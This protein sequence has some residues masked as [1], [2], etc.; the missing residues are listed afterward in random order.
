LCIVRLFRA[1]DSWSGA[2][3]GANGDIGENENAGFDPIFFFLH[4]NVDRVFW[5]WQ[6]RHQATEQ[7]EI[8][9][10]YPGTNNAFDS[11]GP[12][13]R[14]YCSAGCINSSL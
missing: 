14:K 4:C 13:R 12:T 3:R 8:V 1:G 6:Q 11:Q 7:L 9:S 2:F 10:G 5:M